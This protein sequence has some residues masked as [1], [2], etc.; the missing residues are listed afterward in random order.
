VPRSVASRSDWEQTGLRDRLASANPPASGKLIELPKRRDAELKKIQ[1][2]TE[3]AASQARPL[4][5]GFR[6]PEGALSPYP[7]KT[8]GF[9]Q[10]AR[11][12]CATNKT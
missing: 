2:I 5:A 1:G 8:G 4:S 12:R 10:N 3:T 9:L 6:P 11:L 7:G